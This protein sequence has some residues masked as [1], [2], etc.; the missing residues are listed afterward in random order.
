MGLFAKKCRPFESPLDAT[1]RVQGPPFE[2]PLDATLR[3]LGPPFERLRDR[4]V[5]LWDVFCARF[6][7][8]KAP[9]EPEAF[10]G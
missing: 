5:L 1:L 7:T 9:G 10:F 3:V 8:R 2:S 4:V 6:K